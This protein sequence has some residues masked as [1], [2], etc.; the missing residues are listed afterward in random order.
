[1]HVGAGEVEPITELVNIFDSE[2]F[3]K[4]VEKVHGLASKQTHRLSHEEV[5]LREMQE[6]GILQTILP[7][8]RRSY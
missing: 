7:D 8:A 1:M 5:H 4:E 3:T 6:T 2:A